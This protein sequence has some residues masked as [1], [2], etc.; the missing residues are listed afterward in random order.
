MGVH[1][2]SV[3]YGGSTGRYITIRIHSVLLNN[4]MSSEM[5]YLPFI[6]LDVAIT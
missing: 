1:A 3:S 4:E 5:V 6:S 2:I